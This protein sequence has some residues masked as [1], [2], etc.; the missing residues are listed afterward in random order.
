MRSLVLIHIYPQRVYTV[1]APA[2]HMHGATTVESRAHSRCGPSRKK[3][4]RAGRDNPESARK[5]GEVCGWPLFFPVGQFHGWNVRKLREREGGRRGPD[6]DGINCDINDRF[7][8]LSTTKL[9]RERERESV[10]SR[11]HN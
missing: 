2:I 10:V 11:H 6:R 1:N 5:A 4:W 9:Q 3:G 7:K 8:S